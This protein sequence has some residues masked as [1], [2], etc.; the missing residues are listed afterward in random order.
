M[1]TEITVQ[2]KI[3]PDLNAEVEGVFRE[4]GLSAT[5]AITLFY[6]QV[7]LQKRLPF[8]VE[9]PNETTEKTFQDIDAAKNI[10]HCDDADEMFQ[11]LDL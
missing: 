9:V 3:D 11:L 7:K 1:K 5:E 4:L 6:N 2:A 8:D 10:I